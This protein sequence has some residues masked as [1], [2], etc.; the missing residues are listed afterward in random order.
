MNDNQSYHMKRSFKY[1]CFQNQA[2]H[3]NNLINT[4]H[5]IENRMNSKSPVFKK[6]SPSKQVGSTYKMNQ[7]RRKEVDRT[8]NIENQKLLKKLQEIM[9][10]KV[11][12]RGKHSNQDGL[13][14]ARLSSAQNG[15]RSN[16]KNS[17]LNQL[18]ALNNS[19]IINGGIT[20]GSYNQK[21]QSPSSTLR[22]TGST[23]N[24]F[25]HSVMIT[26]NQ[27]TFYNGTTNYN[28]TNS[29]FKNTTNNTCN[30]NP[31]Y[32]HSKSKIL[33][34]TANNFNTSYKRQ[35]ELNTIER[36]N[37]KIAKKITEC[38]PAVGTMD[39]WNQHYLKFKQNSTIRRVI[40]TTGCNSAYESQS[41][42]PQP[43]NFSPA[44]TNQ[45]NA[46]PYIYIPNIQ[47]MQAQYQEFIK[48]NKLYSNGNQIDQQRIFMSHFNSVSRKRQRNISAH[49]GSVNGQ[50]TTIEGMS[51]KDLQSPNLNGIYVSQ[52]QIC[53]Q[54][55]GFTNLNSSQLRQRSNLQSKKSSE[56]LMPNKINN[57]RRSLTTYQGDQRVHYSK[58]E[59]EANQDNVQNDNQQ[60]LK[61]GFNTKNCQFS[62]NKQNIELIDF[63]QM[64]NDNQNIKKQNNGYAF[65][66]QANSSSYKYFSQQKVQSQGKYKNR[67]KYMERSLIDPRSIEFEKL[68]NSQFDFRS[69][70]YKSNQWQSNNIYKNNFMQQSQPFQA[71]N[72]RILSELGFS[73]EENG[74]EN[75][76]QK[77]EDEI[78]GLININMLNQ[79]QNDDK[80]NIENSDNFD[81][82]IKQI[83]EKYIQLD[84]QKENNILNQQNTSQT[85]IKNDEYKSEILPLRNSQDQKNFQLYHITQKAEQQIQTDKENK[86]S[87]I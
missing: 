5:C 21:S 59:N 27:N 68:K 46:K 34:Q 80:S 72:K 40:T 20:V 81:E 52:S 55:N 75:N 77:Q 60:D 53:T 30:I 65:N 74:N 22:N 85:I 23:I 37:I 26:Q 3:F 62:D 67:T 57:Y 50:I 2:H 38:K 87:A 19:Q 14:Y 11:N 58:K 45:K 64:Q 66:D 4:K 12:S 51:Q 31:S 83:Q 70:K 36:E 28:S 49:T 7:K 61:I 29:N 71:K 73:D 10:P 84:S 1:M 9:E 79:F 18:S 76:K 78:S 25:T 42:L 86:E 82:K 56:D 15:P 69:N 41:Y 33:N 48:K 44:V 24:N 54:Q 63:E 13:I 32:D 43:S 39:E 8:I 16:S 35:S 17:N 6:I 47:N